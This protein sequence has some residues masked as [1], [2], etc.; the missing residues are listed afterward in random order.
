MKRTPDPIGVRNGKLV[1]I[2]AASE[3]YGG[4]RGVVLTCECDCGRIYK[5]AKGNFLKLTHCGCVKRPAV[6]R[7]HGE[8]NKSPSGTTKEYRAW[9][10]MLT[11]V[12]NPKQKTYYLYGGRGIK[13]CKR[14]EKYENFLADMGRAP[15]PNHSLDRI[16]SDRDYK[17]SNCRWATQT[18]QVENRRITIKVTFDGRNMPLTEACRL[19]NIS[20]R[21]VRKRIKVQRWSEI[22]A[23]TTPPFLT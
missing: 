23:L 16:N 22:D 13:V 15:T 21:L 17:P 7:T 14:W 4:Q 6:N 2:S 20:P 8:S 12:N 19:Q 1:V 5:C 10:A 11:R 3:I 18:E 9:S